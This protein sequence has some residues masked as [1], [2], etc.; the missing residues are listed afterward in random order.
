M[1]NIPRIVYG[2][3]FT[4][5]LIVSQYNEYNEL[6]LYDLTKATDL[7]LQ[8]IC[9]VHKPMI[10]L[11]FEI[12]PNDSSVLIVNID[13]RLTHPDAMYGFVLS[14]YDENEQHFQWMQ[15]PT[16]GI[17][18]VEA[19]SSANIDPSI[20]NTVDISARIGFSFNMKDYYNKEDIDNEFSY[21]YTKEEINEE[22][23]Y[24]YTQSQINFLLNDK[25]DKSSL[26][27]VATSGNYND[28]SNLPDLSIYAIKSS[29][30][31]VANTGDYNDLINKPDIS[32]T[33]EQA[34]WNESNSTNVTY[35]KNKPTLSSVATSGNYNDLSNKP[36]IPTK[37]SELNNDSNFTTETYVNNKTSGKQDT[38][39]SG[40]NI[41]TVNGT[42]LLG[43][44]NIVISG[45]GIQEQADWNE[46]NST[47]VTYIKNKPTLSTVATSGNYNDLSNKPTIP[48]KT[49]DLNNDSGFTTETYVNNK[50]SGK[51]DILVS[52]QNIKTVNNQSILGS[53]NID[54]Q[55]GQSQEQ[56]DWNE[57][58]I[59]S[60]S[61]IK[62]KPTLSTVATS[63]NYND[64]NNKPDLSI[65]AQSGNLSTVATS[66]DYNDLSNK[67]TIIT[68]VQSDWN[69][70]NN[71]YLSYIQNK[72]NV[73]TT[74]YEGGLRIEVVAALPT[75]TQ[76]NVIYIVQ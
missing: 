67:P 25:A 39:V 1:I 76:N 28:L 72:P 70:S 22:F 48:T 6:E 58:N 46:S 8:M 47:N 57:T 45:S 55:P 3:D 50:T 64:L 75:P 24:Y 23:S 41:K 26:S 62:N 11:E 38:L 37:T 49:S 73:V 29:L 60:Y 59:T 71:T 56:A 66:G 15:K 2:N 7:E 53:G 40:Q 69:E 34:D 61:Y 32:F 19:S 44:G 54:I 12:D 68:P 21:Y 31:T 65:Y 43:S 4:L 63:G 9:S 35:I 18:I 33:Q 52:G 16:E 13:H 30:A 14:G 74:S 27:T 20:D 10:E 51:Q 17:M 5:R 36:T 42:S